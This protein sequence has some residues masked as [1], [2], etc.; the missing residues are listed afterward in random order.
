MRKTSFALAAL[1][2]L[3]LLVGTASAQWPHPGENLLGL[4]TSTDGAGIANLD[5][6][7]GQASI[8]LIAT[9][10]TGPG[11]I[12]GWE[13]HLTYT[14]PADV[15][16][17]APVLYGQAL[18]VSTYP[19]FAVGFGGPALTADAN[20]NIALAEFKFIFLS[21][22]SM[23]LYLGPSSRPSIP[24]VAVYAAGDDPGLLIPF[25]L[26]S[27]SNDAPCFGF[28]TGTFDPPIP[29]EQETFGAV[30]NLYR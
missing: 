20:G 6:A 22:A 12:L 13:C 28:N 1:A 10:T 29:V 30:K 18:N 9:R 24:D 27:G 15:I 8:F 17:G 3:T 25:E 26:S 7:A 2:A 16:E 14:L 19:D 21:A 11:G 4:Y 5:I 23:L